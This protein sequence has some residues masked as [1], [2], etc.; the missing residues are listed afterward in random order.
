[1][2]TNVK[3]IRVKMAASAMMTST[4]THA[5]AP[6][7]TRTFTAKV[8]SILI[9]FHS[10]K[11]VNSTKVSPFIWSVC[12]EVRAFCNLLIIKMTT[13]ILAQYQYINVRM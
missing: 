5:N 9:K 8:K 11:V 2:W 13:R 10:M 4:D 3:A 6:M 12:E 1:M 7:A